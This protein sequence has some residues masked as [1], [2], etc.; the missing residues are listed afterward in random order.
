M[1]TEHNY[2]MFSQKRNGQLPQSLPSIES[3]KPNEGDG[4]MLDM[5]WLF[6]VLRRRAAVMAVA[7]I[8]LTGISGGWIVWNSRKISPEYEGSFRVLVEPVSAE[9]RLAKLS[10][11]GQTSSGAAVTDV[12]RLSVA[13]SD[14]VDYETQ[15]RVLKSPKLMSTVVK[16]LQTRYP[17]INYNSLNEKVNISRIS[18]EKDGRQQGTKLLEVRYQDKNPEKIKYVLNELKTVYLNYSLEERQISLNKGIQFIEQQMPELQQRVD[19]LQGQMQKLRQD[20]NLSNPDQ[21]GKALT[22]QAQ[23]LDTQT[24]EI[25]GKLAEARTEYENLRRQLNNPEISTPVL[26]AD[27]SKSLETILIELQRV[28]TEIAKNSTQFRDNSPPMQDLREKQQNLRRLWRQEAEMILDNASGRIKELES[29]AQTLSKAQRI[30]N[31]KIAIF[32]SVLRKYADLERDL[33]VSTDS[34]KQFLTK[35]EALR[36]D[37]S[38]REIPW[39]LIAEPNIPLDRN[40]QP[41]PT[42]VKQTK[43]QLAIAGILSLLLGV[44]VGFVVEILHTVF[45]TPEELK[46]AT[47]LPLLGVVPFAKEL[48]RLANKS[49]KRFPVLRGTGQAR[50]DGRNLVL[51]RDATQGEWA[52]LEAFRSL[53]TNIR[54]L[55][56]NRPIHSLAISSALPGDGKSTVALYLAQTAA[57]IGQR[58]LLVDADMRRPQLHARLGLPNEQG[59]SD[60][61][62][63][64]ISLNDTI[65]RSPVE[66]N[67][68][69]LTAGQ[70]PSDPIKLLSSEKMQYLMEQFQA[71]FDLVIYDTPPIVGLADSNLIATHTDGM[72][73]VVGL[74]KTDRSMLTKALDGV[75]ISGSPVLGV[76]ANGIK[77]YTP[78]SYA[79]YQRYYRSDRQL[80]R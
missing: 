22:E 73:L 27:S 38:Q 13:D 19:T 48:K 26:G 25:R 12:S 42:S 71:F 72:V 60:A 51:G 23:Y 11:L 4:Q 15:M 66:D 9:G 68:F 2:S 75:K 44:G 79:S 29:R 77:G 69:V 24:I 67:L 53:Y 80:V 31:Q 78:S 16:D 57:S 37:A 36:L 39:E 1:D 74:E 70:I 3:A 35:R 62:A 56:A 65:Q 50:Q 28:E 7:T 49:K 6:A 33:A 21:T 17:D 18:Y 45:H 8:A 59:L 52:F 43:R 54:L 10:L 76:V 30:I 40:N 46:G 14:L 64:D 58:V 32:P 41:I 55:S 47:R 61:I 34:L 63:T 20:Y 5:A